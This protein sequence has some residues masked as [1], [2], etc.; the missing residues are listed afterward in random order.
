MLDLNK[1][2]QEID[3]ILSKETTESLTEWRDNYRVESFYNTIKE[4][5]N[6][7]QQLKLLSLIATNIPTTDTKLTSLLNQISNYK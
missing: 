5:L 6:N 4:S 3:E 7:D 2:E 1:L